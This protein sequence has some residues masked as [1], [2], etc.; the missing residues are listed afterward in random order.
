MSEDPSET[1]LIIPGL[2]SLYD[3][4]AILA[5]PMVRVVAGLWL[6]PHGGAKLFGWYGGDITKT[7]GFFAKMGFEPALPLAYYIGTLEFFGGLMIAIGFLTR[8]W[9]IQV[10]GMMAVVSFL[11]HWPNGFFWANKGAEYPLMWGV[12]M[13][14]IFIEGGGMLSLDR[15]IGREL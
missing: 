9:A 11:V 6:M 4:L 7:A 8:F 3:R 15:K 14:A 13:L 2:Q 12:I 10:V 1:K 5:Y